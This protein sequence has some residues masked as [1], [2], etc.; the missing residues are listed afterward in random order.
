MHTTEYLAPPRDREQLLAR[1]ADLHQRALEILL[2]ETGTVLT[3]RGRSQRILSV[4][5]GAGSSLTLSIISRSH[6][7]AARTLAM[8]RLAPR[9]A[10]SP[11]YVLPDIVPVQRTAHDSTTWCDSA[12]SVGHTNYRWRVLLREFHN[13]HVKGRSR[14]YEQAR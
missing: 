10:I 3:H 5:S 8:R 9:S 12:G 2:R 1:T 6:V 13:A 4:L 11:K 7:V 14:A